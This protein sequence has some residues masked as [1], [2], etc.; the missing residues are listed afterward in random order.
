MKQNMKVIKPTAI[1]D[2][3]LV[4][5]TVAE[6]DYPVWN[7]ATNYTVGSRVIRTTT[8]RIYERVVAGTTAT[9][10]ENDIVNW[11]DIGPTNKWAM[12]DDVVGTITTASS[13]TL[14][15]VIKP[16]AIS[17][18]AL[19]EV[20]GSLLTVTMKSGTGGAVVYEKEIMLDGSAITS[21][22]DWFFEPYSQRTD[23]VITDLPWHYTTPEITV[24]ITSTNPSSCGVFKVGKVTT[25]GDTQYGAGVEIMDFSKKDRDAFGR[26]YIVERNY[27]KRIDLNIITQQNDFN[28]VFRELAS[29]R[30]IPCIYIA[31]EDTGYEPLIGYGFF[32]S[33]GISVEYPTYNL[34]RLQIETLV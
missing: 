4:S 7:P 33:F 23:I 22:Y 29:L 20:S 14:T 5:S 34:C 19:L 27:S 2:A 3:M 28:R 1:T 10:P 8:H 25:I 31:T 12:F 15:V 26:Y 6:T 32:K 9:L 21:F 13:G 17:G 11:L 24:S 16:G 30:A 18:L